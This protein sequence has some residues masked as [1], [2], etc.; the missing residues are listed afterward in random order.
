MNKL[1]LDKIVDKL[2]MAGLGLLLAILF[3]TSAYIIGSGLYYILVHSRYCGIILLLLGCIGMSLSF[4]L[5]LAWIE[6]VLFDR[7]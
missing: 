6:S 2:L 5:I 1:K 7:I 3:I 4:Y